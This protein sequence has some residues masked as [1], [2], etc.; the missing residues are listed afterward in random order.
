MYVP[1]K[2]K[3]IYLQIKYICI[4]Q[5]E[6]SP[7]NARVSKSCTDAYAHAFKTHAYGLHR[8]RW[9][10]RNQHRDRIV[11]ACVSINHNWAH[12]RLV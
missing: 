4:R 2:N 12:L 10:Q 9:S 8:R 5:F 6:C 11:N 7:L 1:I 3:F